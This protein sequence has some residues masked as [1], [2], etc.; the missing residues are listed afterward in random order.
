MEGRFNMNIY[1]FLVLFMAGL[2]GYSIL[3]FINNKKKSGEVLLE[4]KQY[5]NFFLIFLAIIVLTM[6]VWIYKTVEGDLINKDT[7]Y[8]FVFMILWFLYFGAKIMSKA[9]ISEHGILKYD[10]FS[11]W[12]MVESYRWDKISKT[13][14]KYRLE[15]R[16]RNKSDRVKK[17]FIIVEG[18]KGKTDQIIKKNTKLSKGNKNKKKKKGRK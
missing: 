16:Y 12:D 4:L 13:K 6:G 5:G 15:L 11:P 8:Q 7:I 3:R 1:L 17:M 14:D 18:H 2:L 9:K 10:F